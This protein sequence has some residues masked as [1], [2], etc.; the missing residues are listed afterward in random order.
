MY[1]KELLA[2]ND[3]YRKTPHVNVE[4]RRDCSRWDSLLSGE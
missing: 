4:T 1:V 2:I 3:R